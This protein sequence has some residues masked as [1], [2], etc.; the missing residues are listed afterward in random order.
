M[1][2][3][4][5]DPRSLSKRFN[6]RILKTAMNY[7]LSVK[8]KTYK[9][10]IVN[11]RVLYD[12]SI[13]VEAE[14]PDI[15]KALKKLG[16]S[17]TKKEKR[18]LVSQTVLADL[19]FQYNYDYPIG[20]SLD[21]SHFI[22]VS[23]NDRIYLQ[24]DFLLASCIGLCS[25]NSLWIDYIGVYDVIELGF[26]EI[27]G[28]PIKSLPKGSLEDFSRL[29]AKKTIGERYASDILDALLKESS[30]EMDEELP[31]VSR[32]MNI[33]MDLHKWKAITVAEEDFK[34]HHYIDIIEAP[35]HILWSTFLA[36]LL[37]EKEIVILSID[38]IDKDLIELIKMRKGVII[39]GREACSYPDLFSVIIKKENDKYQLLRN[40]T[41]KDTRVTLR[42]SF[43]P[44]INVLESVL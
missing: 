6:R 40:I 11:E 41:Y 33:V 27:E 17:L 23:K 10:R 38:R 34:G 20:V 2:R 37:S 39:V 7:G 18:A 22:F 35:R 28:I 15:L 43:R 8:I 44:L 32:E 42:E 9:K 24:E 29:L 21:E 36:G 14:N 5:V 16:V 12:A 19:E 4:F 13:L 31:L 26:Q 3:A 25:N 30:L 1:P